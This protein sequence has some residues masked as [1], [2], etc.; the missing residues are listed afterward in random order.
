M[1]Y[2]L[3][4]STL[5]VKHNLLSGKTKVMF[6]VMGLKS[7]KSN[8]SCFKRL[9]KY[10]CM[11]KATFCLKGVGLCILLSLIYKECQ[12]MYTNFQKCYL[13]ITFRS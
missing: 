5:F 6:S 3:V 11:K 4:H 13:C 12:K 8:H 9:T 2:I 10:Y 7:E 1:F